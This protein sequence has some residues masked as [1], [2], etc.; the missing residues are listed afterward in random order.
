MSQIAQKLKCFYFSSLIPGVQ[1]NLNISSQISVNINPHFLAGHN[2]LKNTDLHPPT[3]APVIFINWSIWTSVL[4]LKWLPEAAAVWP[5]SKKNTH[6]LSSFV[7]HTFQQFT[8]AWLAYNPPIQEISCC[9]RDLAKP[10]IHTG[11]FSLPAAL[12]C[13]NRQELGNVL[14][15]GCRW[16]L[17]ALHPWS[18][19]VSPCNPVL[20]HIK[21]SQSGENLAIKFCK[22][23][24]PDFLFPF[25]EQ[26]EK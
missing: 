6:Y 12:P 23:V 13:H 10:W 19:A 7:N 3:S 22:G 9:D 11:L 2:M 4:N 17:Q 21:S 5:Q 24:D 8:Y 25:F 16:Y 14:G 20:L 1:L 15:S 26:F 18:P